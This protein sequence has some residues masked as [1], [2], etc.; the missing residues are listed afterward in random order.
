MYFDEAFLRKIFLNL[1]QNQAAT[2][3]TLPKPIPTWET[4]RF[5][6]NPNS[7]TSPATHELTL[8]KT[9]NARAS[10]ANFANRAFFLRNG[11]VINFENEPLIFP[12]IVLDRECFIL[13]LPAGR[14]QLALSVSREKIVRDNIRKNQL[15]EYPRDVVECTQINTCKLIAILG[16]LI[17]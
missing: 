3:A 4:W 12:D 7:L 9:L 5:R 2:T 11:G 10:D 1:P 8:I 14:A 13:S 17:P 15:R 6:N 16:S